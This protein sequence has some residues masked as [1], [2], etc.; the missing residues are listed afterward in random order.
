MPPISLY[1]RVNLINL[2]KLKFRLLFACI[3]INLQHVNIGLDPKEIRGSMSKILPR[4]PQ[5]NLTKNFASRCQ[6]WRD[7]GQDRTEIFAT[8]TLL[9][10]KN[11]GEI[12]GR[13]PARFWPPGLLLPG[14]NHGENRGR[15][16]PRFWPPG[17]LLLGENLGEIRGRIPTRFLPPGFL[18]PARILER[19][20]VGSRRD[21]GRRDF[22]FSARILASFA[23]GSRRDF[24]RR[25]FR[26]PAR[27][28]PGSRRD[29]C[30][31]EKFRR[32]KS[33]QDPG[34]IPAEIAAGSRQDPG[35]YFTRE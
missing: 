2:Y 3:L 32:P 6:S 9:L 35:P 1:V 21:F 13:I 5:V 15:I 8:V 12:R 25:E 30:Q 11:L 14:E 34:G 16:V 10:S 4:F 28:L 20:A 23:A 17:I 26:F 18:L 22:C 27:I 31:E 24:G 33:R 7:S 19:F 29:S